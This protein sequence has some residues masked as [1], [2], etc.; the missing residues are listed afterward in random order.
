MAQK[1]VKEPSIAAR[2]EDGSPVAEIFSLK[3]EGDKLVM[4]CKVLESA[5]MNVVITVD[6]IVEGWPV[7]SGNRGAIIGFGKK[8]PKAVRRWKK[9]MKSAES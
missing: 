1:K 6:A 2:T 5:R 4:D 3:V 7:V 9:G 8:I